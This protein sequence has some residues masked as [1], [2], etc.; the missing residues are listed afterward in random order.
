MHVMFMKK[1]I[2]FIKENKKFVITISILML[3][4]MFMYWFLKLFQQ[5]P[6]YINFYLDDKIPF[7]GWTVYIYDM[8]YP[9]CLISF[10]LL[11][12][13]DKETYF[14]GVIAGIIGCIICYIIY[15]FLPTI[16]YRPVIPQYDP[17]TNLV[18]K[19]T[20]FFDNPPLNCFPSL[21]C[22]FCFQVLFSCIKATYPIK[23]KIIMI[24]VSLLI[25]LSTLFVKQHYIYDIVSAL[26]VC[27]I[28]NSLESIIG[29]YK[30][31]KKR[32]IL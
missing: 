14:K 29:I 8:F 13:A 16:M 11:Y 7:W 26:L 4:N 23:K 20:F 3:G 9:F 17:L 12:K 30:G 10:Y 15:L 2:K 19:I 32:N 25:V 5:N 22:V 1:I 21:H 24:S 27:L 18:L 6:I 31:F 28:A